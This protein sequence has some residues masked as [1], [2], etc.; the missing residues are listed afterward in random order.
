MST[1]TCDTCGSNKH[2]ARNFARVRDEAEFWR[3]EA[4]KLAARVGQLELNAKL[5]EHRD[6]TDVAWLQGKVVAQRR[7]LKML[8]DRRNI[9]SIK[10]GVEPLAEDV[11]VTSVTRTE[12]D[13]QH[14]EA[15]QALKGT[16]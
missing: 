12:V 13:S 7:E 16:L 4:A 6:R 1:T 14:S 11:E 3:R 2:F 8:N 9:A 15:A 5:A 10:S